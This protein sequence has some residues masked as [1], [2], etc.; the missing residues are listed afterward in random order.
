MLE[1]YSNLL[2]LGHCVPKPKLIAK[3]EQGAEPWIREASNKNLTDVQE[4]EYRTKTYQKSPYDCL[5]E[6]GVMNTNT[7]KKKV[8]LITTFNLRSK[9]KSELIRNNGNSLG[10]RTEEFRQCQNM[11]LHGESNGMCAAYGPG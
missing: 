8:K 9:P 7:G 4:K 5:S 11:L 2:S 1:T 6:V 10:I 3:L